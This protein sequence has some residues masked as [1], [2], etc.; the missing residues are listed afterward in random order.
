MQKAAGWYMAK[1]LCLRR[2]GRPVKESVTSDIET[3][4][5]QRRAMNTAPDLMKRPLESE[6]AL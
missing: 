5:L 3:R 1:D 6:E 2:T 4:E